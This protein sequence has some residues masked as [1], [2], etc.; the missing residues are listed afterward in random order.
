MRICGKKLIILAAAWI[1]WE[2]VYSPA[3]G[4]RWRSI[5]SISTQAHCFSE[6]NRIAQEVANRYDY[7]RPTGARVEVTG[8]NPPGFLLIGA[9]GTQRHIFECYPS[10]F[11]PRPKR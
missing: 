3:G 6:A 2:H 11:D 8:G 1:L 10:D 4:E 9:Q 5:G 7:K